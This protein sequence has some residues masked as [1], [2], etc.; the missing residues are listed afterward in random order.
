MFTGIG[1][2]LGSEAI[3]D[4]LGATFSDPT[5][6]AEF[7]VVVFSNTSGN[8]ILDAGQRANF[9]QWVQSGGSI[10]VIHA[11]TDTYRHSPANGNNT[12]TGTSMRSH[13]CQCSRGPEPCERYSAVCDEPY[14]NLILQQLLFQTRG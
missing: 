11:A 9:E 6:L 13:R 14:R 2:E 12:G 1:S 5:A 7:D 8:N 3:N 4:P 10:L